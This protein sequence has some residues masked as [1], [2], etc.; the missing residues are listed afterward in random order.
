[1]KKKRL[2]LFMVCASVM[3]PYP[4]DVQAQHGVLLP[5]EQK[6]THVHEDGTVCEGGHHHN[7]GE[8]SAAGQSRTPRIASGQQSAPKQDE[9]VSNPGKQINPRRVS[10]GNGARYIGGPSDVGGVQFGAGESSTVKNSN[11]YAANP[12]F[13]YPVN[14]NT[15]SAVEIGSS[16]SKNIVMNNYNAG[17]KATGFLNI[18]ATSPQH[19]DAGAIVVDASGFYEHTP[20]Y[21]APATRPTGSQ[22]GMYDANAV[23]LNPYIV[24]FSYWYQN[25]HQLAGPLWAKVEINEIAAPSYRDYISHLYLSN[26]IPRQLHHWGVKSTEKGGKP[27][28]TT[29]GLQMTTPNDT[30]D[31]GIH[32]VQSVGDAGIT[33]SADIGNA[34]T[35]DAD[36]LYVRPVTV[37]IDGK[38]NLLQNI[39]FRDLEWYFKAHN[40]ERF[41][42]NGGKWYTEET[43]NLQ[44]ELVGNCGHV[45]AL[46]LKL[47][48]IGNW[49][50]DTV[51]GANKLDAAV[52]LLNDARVYVVDSIADQTGTVTPGF[53]YGSGAGTVASAGIKT[54]TDALLVFPD[55]DRFTLRVK[56]NVSGINMKHRNGNEN[57]FFTESYSPDSD[58]PDPDVN[59]YMYKGSGDHHFNTIY[60]L[61]P[62]NA[63]HR[64]YPLPAPYNTTQAAVFGVYGDYN[65]VNNNAEIHTAGSGSVNSPFIPGTD[66]K[67]DN[68]GVIETGP[69]DSK[70]GYKHFHIYSG[71]MLKNF[72]W[73]D[74]TRN[75]GLS[76]TT[77]DNTPEFVIDGKNPLYIVNFGNNE[78]GNSENAFI[79]FA[80]AGITKLEEAL[81]GGSNKNF[82][83]G[84]LHIQARGP[85]LFKTAFSP[86]TDSHSNELRILSD[87]GSVRYSD[88]FNYTNTTDAHLFIVAQGNNPGRRE[89]LPDTA[90]PNAGDITFTGDVNITQNGGGLTFIRSQFD[91]ITAENAFNY[92]NTLSNNSAGEFMMQAGQDIYG[93]GV[94]TFSLAGQKSILFEAGNT[95]HLKEEVNITKTAGTRDS[96][97][98]KAGYDE[99]SPTAAPT[100]ASYRPRANYVR[101][102]NSS[103]SDAK[104]YY[105]SRD[106]CSSAVGAD[107]WF[108]KPVRV[109]LSD[110][111]VPDSVTTT[112]R[113]FNSIYFDDTFDFTRNFSGDAGGK[114][115]KGAGPVTLFAETGNVE[116]ITPGKDFNFN[117]EGADSSAI[118]IQAGNRLDNI[119]AAP[120]QAEFWNRGA[121][122]FAEFDGN[123]LFNSKLNVTSR[124]TGNLLLSATRDIETQTDGEITVSYDEAGLNPGDVTLTAGRHIETHAPVNI[125][126]ARPLDT[127]DILIR[128]GRLAPDTYT[129]SDLLCK[130]L[131]EGTSLTADSHGGSPLAPYDMTQTSQA[132]N[133]FAAGGAGQGSIFAFAPLNINVKSAGNILLS[134]P[135]GNIVTDPYLHRAVGGGYPGGAAITVNHSE[136]TGVTR[137][138]AID[139][140]L[141]DMLA[142]IADVTGDKLRNGQFQIAA[143][144]SILT[145]KLKYTNR[146]DTGS[147]FITTDKYKRTSPAGCDNI[148]AHGHIVLGYGADGVSPFNVSDSILFDFRGNPSTEGAC[149]NI[150]A[151][152]AGYERNTVTGKGRPP[153]ADP[154]DR[155][156]GWGGNITWD[157]MEIYMPAGNGD[158]GG[159]TRIMTPNGNIWGKDSLKYRGINGNLTVD[160]G[161]GSEDDAEHAVNGNLLNTQAP[162]NCDMQA[163]SWRTGNII[164]KGANVKFAE[165]GNIGTGNATFRTR[166]GFID[167]YDAFTVDSMKTFLLKYAGMDDTAK[168]KTNNW[169]DL[170]ERDFA[171]AAPSEGIDIFFA[172][173]DNIMLNYGN[174]SGRYDNGYGIL[175]SQTPGFPGHYSPASYARQ[176]NPYYFTSYAGYIDGLYASTYDVRKDGYLY[177]RNPN[178]TP[179]VKSHLLYRGCNVSG[180]ARD[181]TVDFDANG[182]GRGGFA[183]VAGN[184]ID[185]FTKFIYRGGAGSGLGAVPGRGTLHG[186]KVAGYGL[187]LK[188]QF[189][190]T[191]TNAP[192]HRRATCENCGTLS[193][194]P[195]EGSDSEAISE[196]TYV[197]FHD[198]A[199]IHTQQQQSWIEAPVI[200]FFGHAEL[201]AYTNRGGNTKITLKSD[202][203]IFHDSIIFDGLYRSNIDF[204]PFTVDSA[205]RNSDM[206]YGVINDRGAS[207]NNYKNIYK[208]VQE[209]EK[210]GP[211]I[212]MED[213]RLPVLELGYQRCTGPGV[214]LWDAPNDLSRA[215]REYTPRVGGDV[216]LAFKHGF[217]LPV[218]NTV[219][220]NNARISFLTGRLGEHTDAF[221]RTDLLRIRNRAEFYTDPLHPESR[222]GKF[223]LATPAQMDDV[224]Q[225]VGI[226]MRHLHTEPGSELSIPGEDSIIVIP[227]TVVGGYGHIHENIFVKEGGILAPG[228]ASLMEADCQTPR[229]QGR[230]T[231]HNLTMEQNSILRVS[232]SNRNTC[233]DSDG[234]ITG[235][236]QTDT[237]T[238]LGKVRIKGS[239]PLLVLPEEEIVEPGCYLFMEYDDADSESHEYV[240]NM[241]LLAQ[242][243]GDNYFTLDFSTPGKVYLCV[244]KFP[245][246]VVQRYV[247]LPAFEG[248]TYNYVKVNGERAVHNIGR[249]YVKGHHNFEVNLTWTIP[250]LKA[251]AH[252]FYSHTELDMDATSVRE[253]D[254]SVTYIIRRVVEPWTISFGPQPSS[255]SWVDNENIAGQNIWTHRNTLY[256]S[257]PTDNTV[258]IYNITGVLNRKVEIPAGLSQMI[259]DKGIYII[260]L[261]D[262]KAY[263]IVVQ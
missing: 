257:T 246:P 102:I 98:F 70:L 243:Y 136:G 63:G 148:I 121:E 57:A 212:A 36:N 129:C 26:H 19:Y 123:I 238:V 143:F 23:I 61:Q 161:L 74:F 205:R 82:D 67:D 255:A 62:F 72:E 206:R 124:G 53:P 245:M 181:L 22:P 182:S 152:Y 28:T 46:G 237:V 2:F 207:L 114:G 95:I 218:F 76:L 235:C 101:T 259:L 158:T 17:G 5:E 47:Y 138:E 51:A 196:M 55:T 222:S 60:A 87:Q 39:V 48:Q 4:N 64:D 100:S 40:L 164:M 140:K 227:T 31:N 230:L 178:Y 156:K 92:S 263:K 197:G 193:K 130:V 131:E 219:V 69:G 170:S 35:P 113:A 58:F 6:C 188:S 242:R 191:G 231:V 85:V 214:M 111:A 99:F 32:L 132:P 234:N 116:A 8:N 252:G 200:E 210:A 187:F 105:S 91:D 68:P 160:A 10:L 208:D 93:K 168:A 38:D 251:W 103:A 86:V 185:L 216:V 204:L 71:G 118:V 137:L 179:S 139:V 78:S 9:A 174:S 250:P 96:I 163:L 65:H 194:F 254:G 83:D 147:V 150:L 43:F 134:A 18:T 122:T 144:D 217:K 228:Y 249:N 186:E 34:I 180:A 244:T 84:A 229:R 94:W 104:G 177:Y 49:L 167:T 15:V 173:D 126:Y 89:C 44:N 241:I 27:Y 80:G 220:A 119:C 213:R 199:R 221:I 88:L 225:D 198:D 21:S 261:K 171:F 258:S 262:G 120:V 247:D 169:G 52:Q 7:A 42:A 232:I 107:I 260:K 162:A 90:L 236:M 75:F 30:V 133:A 151:G 190:G 146:T 165:N 109:N 117:I 253:A 176:P 37:A 239:V 20:P 184:Y 81:S 233:R 202:S 223:V 224:M 11:P 172:A 108:E 77:A 14:S 226:Y 183:A 189:N 149:L 128:A 41:A 142:Y 135:N 59:I 201:D 195:I 115:T 112:F 24:D 157:Y 3:M 141:H 12:V 54:A 106:E 73:Y 29:A 154:R 209:R 145:R 127:A 25:L 79:H 166:E 192:E 155:D 125:T 153:F 1:M 16:I 45:G 215:G 240:R 50:M 159:S 248:I 97:T 203:L 13:L 56:G 211:A 110:A 66:G 33:V 256:I 175:A